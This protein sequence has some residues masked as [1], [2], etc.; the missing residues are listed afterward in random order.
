[1]DDMHMLFL[2]CVNICSNIHS[3]MYIRHAESSTLSRHENTRNALFDTPVWLVPLFIQMS[4]AWIRK[5]GAY[6]SIYITI[7]SYSGSSIAIDISHETL[8]STPKWMLHVVHT[9]RIVLPIWPNVSSALS[10]VCVF[11]DIVTFNTVKL[12]LAKRPYSIS[13]MLLN[14]ICI[15]ICE[16]LSANATNGYLAWLGGIRLVLIWLP[17]DS[18]FFL[19]GLSRQ[20]FDVFH[21]GRLLWII[22]YLNRWGNFHIKTYVEQFFYNGILYICSR[23]ELELCM[24]R[25]HDLNVLDGIQFIMATYLQFV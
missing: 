21:W 6:V 10:S 5:N 1:M 12:L 16:F 18:H 20:S 7:S 3:F 15:W 2:E 11:V 8:N 25:K 4:G 22:W 14:W 9:H 24:N 23:I 19:F 13:I 17:R